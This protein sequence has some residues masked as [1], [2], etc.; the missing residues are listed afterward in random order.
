M[1]FI[2]YTCWVLYVLTLAVFSAYCCY[3]LLLR[4]WVHC[5]RFLLGVRNPRP[6]ACGKM[7]SIPLFSPFWTCN[8]IRY[9]KGIGI[10]CLHSDCVYDNLI[11]GIHTMSIWFWPYKSGVTP[12]RLDPTTGPASSFPRQLS[13]TAME[14]PLLTSIHPTASH[15]FPLVQASSPAPPSLVSHRRPVRIGRRSRADETGGEGIKSCVS[16]YWAKRLPW[17]RPF[18]LGGPRALWIQPGCTLLFIIFHPI[19]S[20]QFK[21]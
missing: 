11:L 17:D 3:V 2:S 7:G 1:S 18:P 19:Y 9:N 14:M 20:N 4:R 8:K 5:W 10:L 12:E 6:T 13:T 16:V 21:F 15:E